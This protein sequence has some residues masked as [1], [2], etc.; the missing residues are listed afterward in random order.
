MSLLLVSQVSALNKIQNIGNIII[1]EGDGFVLDLL[2]Y[3]S[4]LNSGYN[5]LQFR[6][7][8]PDTNQLLILDVPIIQAVSGISNPNNLHCNSKF[9][10]YITSPYQVTFIGKEASVTSF[11][12]V[13]SNNFQS[14]G[15]NFG[16]WV[17]EPDVVT[18]YTPVPSAIASF[19]D[20]YV[21]QFN[22]VTYDMKNFFTFDDYIQVTFPNSNGQTFF[23]DNKDGLNSISLSTNFKITIYRQSGRSFLYIEPLTTNFSVNI[24]ITAFNNAGKGASSVLRVFGTQTPYSEVVNNDTPF[25]PPINFSSELLVEQIRRFPLVSYSKVNESDYT[26]ERFYLNDYVQG[27]YDEV[28]ILVNKP[29]QF[30]GGLNSTTLNIS[31][32][33]SVLNDND[34]ILNLFFDE[35]LGFYFTIKGKSNTFSNSTYLND[36]LIKNI[37]IDVILKNRNSSDSYIIK[38]E[39]LGYNVLPAISNTGMF[40]FYSVVDPILEFIDVNKSFITSFNNTYYVVWN[41]FYDNF[42]YIDIDLPIYYFNPYAVVNWTPTGNYGLAHFITYVIFEGQSYQ[43]LSNT[44]EG[45]SPLTH[46][47]KFSLTTKNPS[48]GNLPVHSLDIC[49][50]RVGVSG[51][52]SLA[53]YSNSYSFGNSNTFGNDYVLGEVIDYENFSI[54]MIFGN[55]LFGSIIETKNVESIT[56]LNVNFYRHDVNY[57]IGVDEFGDCIFSTPTTDSVLRQDTFILTIYEILAGSI[58]LTRNQEKTV[59]LKDYFEIN[60][61]ANNLWKNLLPENTNVNIN[62]IIDYQTNISMILF[63]E[64]NGLINTIKLFPTGNLNNYMVN[65]VFY[66]DEDIKLSLKNNN[67]LEPELII[68]SK[69]K[70]FNKSLFIEFDNGGG[71]VIRREIMFFINGG[72]IIQQPSTI[73]VDGLTTD[74]TPEFLKNIPKS[75]RVIISIFIII[76]V[77]V[78]VLMI[79][80]LNS[81]A[82]V[83]GAGSIMVG[84]LVMFAYI[85]WLPVWIPVVVGVFSVLLLVRSFKV[86]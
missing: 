40:A 47:L 48:I 25:I 64:R 54:T 66:E 36:N 57:V 4:L 80:G 63:Y 1:N 56:N 75:Q 8:N 29:N 72:S 16:L 41:D 18:P 28:T 58:N 84:L 26:L 9:C 17:L 23:D 38:S 71:D 52:P 55:G 59:L 37:I 78:G 81:D 22:G 49:T 61:K 32:N 5:N 30:G 35:E 76:L 74:N 21:S 20:L 69:N 6:F 51:S 31:G 73:G 67:D 62:N 19:P 34:Y 83:F 68:R 33:L 42:N 77:V 27:N 85:G 7:I 44:E 39:S 46:P 70:E 86:D 13:V 11:Q 50:G 10:L 53:F 79:P 82:R 45:E 2:D 24:T 60:T 3:H 43:V 14:N 15:Q 12:L 65:D